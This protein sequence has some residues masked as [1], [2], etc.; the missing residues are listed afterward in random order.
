[1]FLPFVVIDVPLYY[2]FISSVTG[3]LIMEMTYGMDIKSHKDRFL[4]A[5][6]H[7]M[8]H[9]EAA[10]VPGTFLVNTFPIRSSSVP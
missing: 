4:Q 5:A 9:L 10:V 7:A 3:A 6:E 1:M 2:F 8:E